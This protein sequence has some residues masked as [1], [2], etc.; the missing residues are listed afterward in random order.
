[1]G[2][3]QQKKKNAK[4]ECTKEQSRMKEVIAIKIAQVYE[5]KHF[6]EC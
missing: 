6:F 4:R 5:K 3:Q 2:Q 1:M